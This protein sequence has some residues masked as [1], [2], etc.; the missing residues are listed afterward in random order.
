M[1][2]PFDKKYQSGNDRVGNPGDNIDYRIKRGISDDPD[3]IKKQKQWFL[4]KAKWVY[5][6]YLRDDTYIPYS[7]TLDFRMNRLYAQGRQPIDKYRKMLTIFDQ[8]SGKRKGWMNMSWDICPVLPKFIAILLGKFED[9]DYNIQIRAI[10]EGSN[11]ARDEAKLTVQIEAKYAEI[12]NELRQAIGMDQSPEMKDAKLPY[13]PKSAEE[14]EMMTQLG[15]LRLSWE[16]AMDYLSNQTQKTINWPEIKRRLMEDIV[17]LGVMAVKDYQDPQ[18]NLPM[19]R[20]VDPENL[21]IRQT[22]HNDFFDV[23]EAG[24]IVWY[25]LEQLRSMG[26]TEEEIR[27]VG[28]TYQNIFGNGSMN[29]VFANQPLPLTVQGGIRGAVLDLEF[30]SFDRQFYE[31]RIISGKKVTFDLPHGAKGPTNKKNDYW[32]KEKPKVYRCK[33]V[34]GTDI[35]FD[36]GLQYDAPYKQNANARL[37]YSCY[38]VNERSMVNQCQA[39]IDDFQM[40]IYKIRNA[41]ATS[42]PAGVQIEVGSISEITMG[43]QKMKPFDVLKIFDDTGN[44][45]Y[46]QAINP[47]NGMPIQGGI[48]PIM[49]LA[50]GIGPYLDELLKGIDFDLNMIRDITG[51]NS[52]VD[53]S[54]PAPNALVGTA[55]IAEMAS[56]YVVRPMLYAYKSVKQRCFANVCVRWQIV[57]KFYPTEVPVSPNNAAFQVIKVT[58]D[59]YDPVFDVFCEALISDDDKMKLDQACQLSLQA[60]K[61]GSIGITLQDYYYLQQQMATGNIRWAWVYLGYRES[62]MKQDAEMAAAQSQAQI[63]EQNVALE[64]KKLQSELMIIRVKGEED[65]KAI[66][67]KGQLELQKERLAQ[68]APK[69]PS[70]EQPKKQPA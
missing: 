19:V 8:A 22:R 36:Y 41:V 66:M 69:P 46:R 27:Q 15:A 60:A 29:G 30:Q 32:V 31:G 35:I 65:R 38:R 43:G 33:W 14:L 13:I 20:Y 26:L 51:L 18:T 40:K 57:G 11:S 17:V 47:Q 54:A 44:I 52:V 6:S 42:R 58:K 68:Q 55:K 67:L 7:N 50:G 23:T 12:L 10:D 34:I 62:K 45:I 4:D 2:A 59:M 48:P 56:N 1:A 70:P 37:S 9:I 39:V 53:S 25:T 61:T 3:S 63:G 16:I 5:G 64:E 28:V 24:E 21:I 49:P